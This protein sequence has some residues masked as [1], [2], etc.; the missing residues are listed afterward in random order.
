MSTKKYAHKVIE[1]CGHEVLIGLG[2]STGHPG[3]KGV[4]TSD[5]RLWVSLD[6]E[7]WFKPKLAWSTHQLRCLMDACKNGGYGKESHLFSVINM[8]KG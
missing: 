4:Q 2:S 7:A 5:I 1:V 8:L 3:S 6:G